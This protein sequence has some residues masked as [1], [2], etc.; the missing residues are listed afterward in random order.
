MKTVALAIALATVFAIGIVCASYWLYSTYI[1]V[2]L[3]E[4]T[5]TLT[6]AHEGLEVTLTATLTQ[7]GIPISGKTIEF[8]HGTNEATFSL[9]GSSTTNIDG[10]ATYIIHEPSSGD[11]DYIARTSVP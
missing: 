1:Q 2:H 9:I 6:E 3:T 7:N 5:L 11:Y 8:G 10:I 4:P